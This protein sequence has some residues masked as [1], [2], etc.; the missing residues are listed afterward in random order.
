MRLAVVALLATAAPAALALEAWRATMQHR[1]AA[2]RALRHYAESAAMSFRERLMSELYFAVDRIFEPIFIAPATPPPGPKVLRDAAEEL[3]RC[4]SCGPPLDPTYFFR[5][6]LLDS[7]LALD[8]PPL[9]PRRR[10]ELLARMWELDATRLPPRRYTSF[11]DTLGAAPEVVYLMLRDKEIYGFAVGLVQVADTVL[12]PLLGE[13]GLVPTV[14][15]APGRND[16]L[17]S[18]TLLEPKGHRVLDLSAERRPP[19]YSAT[20]PASR[21][22]G[23]WRLHLALDPATAPPYLIGGLPPSRTLPLALLALVTAVL[24]C[25]TVLVAWRAQELARLRT[26]FVASVSHE[27]RTPLAQVQLFA[28][29]LALGRM[30]ARRDVRDAG[31]VI[32]GEARRLLQLVE[33]VVLFGRRGRRL[34]PGPPYPSLA[35]APLIRETVESFAPVAAAADARVRTV[36]LDDVVAPA[37]R[38]ALRQ[39]LLNLLDNAVKYGRRG[40]TISVGLALAGGSARLWVED[41]GPGIPP[42]ERAAVWEPFVRLARDLESSTAGSGIGL[43]IVRELV[44][45]HGGAARIESAPGG[46]ACVVVELPNAEPEEQPCAS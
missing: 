15:L 7:A 35:L 4:A 41:E 23:N 33:N 32:L 13:I 24:V 28:E 12:R 29:S 14:M 34:V 6:T 39:V 9:P 46:G 19:T 31:R 8:G 3:R 22:L 20:I 44:E 45:L 26:D 21:F 10:T 42:A 27:L 5:V 16:S 2:E 11:V 1:D 36:R 18:I 38:S 40:Q 37:E 25:A 30:H 17:L 43:A